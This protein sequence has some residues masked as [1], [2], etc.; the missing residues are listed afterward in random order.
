[1]CLFD[2]KTIKEIENGG[3][4]APITAD[5]VFCELDEKYGE[6][7]T[8]G[9][10]PFDNRTFVSELK[11]EIGENAPLYNEPIY[12]VAKSYANDDVLY[13]VGSY[14]N[15]DIYRI[16]HLTYSKKNAEGFPKYKEFAGI[17]AVKGYIESEFS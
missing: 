11:K 15:A 10:I 8:W 2:E 12:A 13:W 3:G 5:E 16:Y 1:M 17:L 4:C 6:E 7:F 9:M 14:M